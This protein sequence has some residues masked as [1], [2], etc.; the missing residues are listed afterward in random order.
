MIVK[1]PICE[2]FLMRSKQTLAPALTAVVDL[3]HSMRRLLLLVAV[4]HMHVIV[5][6]L[7]SRKHMIHRYIPGSTL[8]LKV[9]T[10]APSVI[11]AVF[12][13]GITIQIYAGESVS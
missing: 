12:M 4:R 13:H 3:H 11:T 8:V 7:D 2:S 9:E 6:Q 5:H 10:A 1:S